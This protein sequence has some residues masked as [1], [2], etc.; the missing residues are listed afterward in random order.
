MPVLS[1]GKNLLFDPLS[2][3]NFVVLCHTRQKILP[4][5]ASTMATECECLITV[6]QVTASPTTILVNLLILFSSTSA[7][8]WTQGVSGYVP[9]H[10]LAQ[11]ARIKPIIKPLKNQRVISCRDNASLKKCKISR[12]FFSPGSSKKQN[13]IKRTVKS[14]SYQ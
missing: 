10:Q 5:F 11:P 7:V 4:F 9:R 8:S 6:K 12:H 14:G 3:R 2:R 1:T 13:G